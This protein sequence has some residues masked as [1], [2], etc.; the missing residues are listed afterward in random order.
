MGDRTLVTR[1]LTAEMAAQAYPLVREL[2]GAGSLSEWLAFAREHLAKGE[3]GGVIVCERGSYI[4]GLFG[5]ET[6]KGVG[7]QR[8][9]VVRHFSVPSVLPSRDVIDALLD[10]IDVLAKKLACQEIHLDMPI[11]GQLHPAFAEHGLLPGTVGLHRR[12]ST[13]ETQ[14]KPDA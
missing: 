12:I 9:L 8:Q 4:R 7:G 11:S 14:R 3:E 1:P 5:W 13:Y 6:D 2:S 10:A